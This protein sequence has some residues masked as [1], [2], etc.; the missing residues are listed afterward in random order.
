FDPK[1]YRIAN[2]VQGIKGIRANHDREDDVFWAL[3]MSANFSTKSLYRAICLDRSQ[4]LTQQSGML[5]QV[6]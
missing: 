4:E 3:E 6:E 2:T 1:A 5:Q